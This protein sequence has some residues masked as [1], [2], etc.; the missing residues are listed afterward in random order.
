MRQSAQANSPVSCNQRMNNY[1]KK[2][3]EICDIHE[4]LS[5][6]IARHSYATS[7]SL[8]NGVS[9]ENL[10]KIL[11]HTDT[12]ITRTLCT[13]AGPKYYGRYTESK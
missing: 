12:S 2:N 10:A 7:I 3:A 13:G 11:R 6:H 5:T 1:L 4:K 8:T 9:M